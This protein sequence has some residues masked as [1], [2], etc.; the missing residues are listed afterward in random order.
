MNVG[1]DSGWVKALWGDKFSTV[2]SSIT[3]SSHPLPF[4]LPLIV[5]SLFNRFH[6]LHVVTIFF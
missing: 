3:I 2:P 1:T 6:F 5:Y 4:P